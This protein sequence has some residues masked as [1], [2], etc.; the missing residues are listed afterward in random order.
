MWKLL[1]SPWQT[2]SIPFALTPIG[3][4]HQSPP[5]PVPGDLGRVILKIELELNNLNSIL[6]RPPVTPVFP[7]DV[8]VTSLT[9]LEHR[10]T[11]G[12][13]QV[14]SKGHQGSSVNEL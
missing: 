3:Q 2:L 1:D 5:S 12:Q 13:A 14:R 6:S 8:P 11:Y 7:E 10:E 9:Q 4:L